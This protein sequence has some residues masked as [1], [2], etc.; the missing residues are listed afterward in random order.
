MEGIPEQS[1]GSVDPIVAQA[2]ESCSI[3]ERLCHK[4]WKVRK[5]VYEELT[6]GFESL[7]GSV[8]E[9]DISVSVLLLFQ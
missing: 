3:A 8:V 9:N 2:R 4:E 5:D 7:D 6:Q 1:D